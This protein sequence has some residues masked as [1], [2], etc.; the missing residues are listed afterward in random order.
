MKKGQRLTCLA[1][2]CEDDGRRG[3]GGYRTDSEPDERP[4]LAFYCPECTE[5]ELGLHDA[6]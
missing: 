2:G 4:Q 6:A 1:C 3:W 5:R